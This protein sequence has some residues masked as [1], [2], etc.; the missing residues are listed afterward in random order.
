MFRADTAAVFI[1]AALFVT[2]VGIVILAPDVRDYLA[3]IPY[4]ADCVEAAQ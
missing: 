4:C 2:I 1:A 3:G